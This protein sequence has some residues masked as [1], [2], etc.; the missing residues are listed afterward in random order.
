MRVGND[1]TAYSM[2][3]TIV[4]VG[5]IDGGFFELEGLPTGRYLSIRRDEESA[6]DYKFNLNE[7]KIYQTPNLIVKLQSSVSLTED[8]SSSLAGWEA[9]NLIENLETRSCG[10]G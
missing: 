7:I 4:K 8:T 6:Y 2:F 1:A 5:I 3:N 10:N 9:V